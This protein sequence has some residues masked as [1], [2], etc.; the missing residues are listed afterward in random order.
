M[1]R[2]PDQ[3]RADLAAVFERAGD[4]L[5]R[6]PEGVLIAYCALIADLEDAQARIQDEGETLIV[7]DAKGAPVPHPAVEVVLKCSRE[8]REHGTTVHPKVRRR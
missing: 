4:T 3:V 7:A 8:I 6:I 1:P 5:D 2:T